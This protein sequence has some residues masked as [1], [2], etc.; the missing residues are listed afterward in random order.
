MKKNKRVLAFFLTS[1]SLKAWIFDCE[2]DIATRE[3][4]ETKSFSLFSFPPYFSKYLEFWQNMHAI[5]NPIFLN[6]I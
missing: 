6:V 4:D 3:I 2:K 5:L 1:A